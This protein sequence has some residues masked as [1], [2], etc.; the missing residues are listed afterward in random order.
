VLRS[1]LGASLAEATHLGHHREALPR[2]VVE[3]AGVAEAWML[4]SLT[5]EHMK[6]RSFADSGRSS[7][8]AHHS[9]ECS[10]KIGHFCA[11]SCS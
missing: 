4:I 3:A 7:A 1:R 10:M 2:P 6:L 9:H 5:D 11:L 8:P